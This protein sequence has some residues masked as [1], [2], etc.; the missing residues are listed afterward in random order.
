MYI[1][2]YVYTL[3]LIIHLSFYKHGPFN[4]SCF[5]LSTISKSPKRRKKKKYI[6]GR[7][8]QGPTGICRGCQTSKFILPRRHPSLYRSCPRAQIAEHRCCRLAD[9]QTGRLAWNSD[10]PGAS[11]PCSP[12]LPWNWCFFCSALAR[13]MNPSFFLSRSRYLAKYATKYLVYFVTSP[14]ASIH[15]RNLSNGTLCSWPSRS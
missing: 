6:W 2:I 1:C 7:Q 9:W 15:A 4:S 10:L 5:F 12:P 11:V 14:C 8:Q 13:S 3:L